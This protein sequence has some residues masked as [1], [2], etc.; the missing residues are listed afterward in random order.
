MRA[1]YGHLK[2]DFSGLDHS[3][4]VSYPSF[5]NSWS[6]RHGVETL[7]LL[8]NYFIRQSAISFHAF[9]RMTFHVTRPSDRV[10]VGFLPTKELF[11]S[12]DGESSFEHLFVFT[13]DTSVRFAFTL[14]TSQIFLLR[15]LPH[16]KVFSMKHGYQGLPLNCF[17]FS[18]IT[19]MSQD[20]CHIHQDF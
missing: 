18:K 7:F 12:S 9:L 20:Y 3:P 4:T 10:R 8:L 13:N 15:P 6:S 19:F 16:F 2:G 14:S 11:S 5:L 17:I 1:K